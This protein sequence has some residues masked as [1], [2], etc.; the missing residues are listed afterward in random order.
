MLL[1]GGRY[2]ILPPPHQESWWG[3][4]L[5]RLEHWAGIPGWQISAQ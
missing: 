1:T 5:T 4:G 2:P 3:A